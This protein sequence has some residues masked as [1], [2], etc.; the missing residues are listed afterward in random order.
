VE[1]KTLSLHSFSLALLPSLIPPWVDNRSTADLLDTDQLP[2]HPHSWLLELPN[3][4]GRRG[5]NPVVAIDAVA[6]N[7]GIWSLALL[8]IWLLP[9]SA[10]ACVVSC[11]SLVLPVGVNCSTVLGRSIERSS[12]LIVVHSHVHLQKFN[13]FFLL[14]GY[15]CCFLQLIPMSTA[16]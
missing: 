5:D 11:R 15:H 14:I 12:H 9:R 2:I 8:F 3:H 10:S 4:H 6:S 1:G 16:L 7:S 13:S